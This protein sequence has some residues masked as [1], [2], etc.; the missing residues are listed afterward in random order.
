MALAPGKGGCQESRVLG[1]YL[2]PA[3]I[4]PVTEQ[5]H[6]LGRYE[7]PLSNASRLPPSNPPTPGAA[8]GRSRRRPSRIQ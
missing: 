7:Y 8:C 2:Y 5:V 6:L 4:L 3:K 1:V